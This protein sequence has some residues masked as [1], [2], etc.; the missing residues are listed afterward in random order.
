MALVL[1]RQLDFK[2]KITNRA[3]Y[4]LR[5]APSVQAS[6]DCRILAS[7]IDPSQNGAHGYA[8]SGTAFRKMA[9]WVLLGLIG[10]S[11]LPISAQ[12]H[13]VGAL[14]VPFFA[15]PSSMSQAYVYPQVHAPWHATLWSKWLTWNSQCRQQ[16]LLPNWF[17]VRYELP[18]LPNKAMLSLWSF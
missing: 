10:D 8:V 18:N 1:A 11:Q 13:R 17:V 7:S 3:H 16:R 6:S 4:F 5:R 14:A 12:W 9:C 2:I 15:A